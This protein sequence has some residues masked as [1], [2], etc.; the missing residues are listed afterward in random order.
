MVSFAFFTEIICDERFLNV[1]A[2]KGLGILS[3]VKL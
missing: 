1:F 2:E 3:V